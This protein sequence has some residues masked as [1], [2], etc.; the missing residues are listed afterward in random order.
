MKRGELYLVDFEP[1][2]EGEP[3]RRRPVVILTNDHANLY[4]S[5]LV[6]APVTTNVV[7]QFPFDVLLPAGTCGLVE[8]SR[9]Q[10]NYI[11]GLNRARIGKYL[12]VLLQ[13]Q[14]EELNLRLKVHLAL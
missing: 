3:A 12:G 5:N 6:V 13:E 7:E 8:T 4:L 14:V 2:R 9:I 11:R 10:L 1:S